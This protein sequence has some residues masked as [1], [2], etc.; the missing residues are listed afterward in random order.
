MADPP[1]LQAIACDAILG[2]V[3]LIAEAWDAGGLY[4]VGSFPSW[5]RWS[6]WNGRYRDDIRQFLK[7]TDGMAGTAITR[8]TGSKI[9]IRSTAET[10]HPLIL[11]PVMMDL[12]CMI[13][14]PIIRSTMRKR[15]E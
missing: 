5:N 14:M 6:E 4:Q 3:K 12:H 1:L 10:V 15:L 9:F 13:C 2:K 8:I 11:S 7:G